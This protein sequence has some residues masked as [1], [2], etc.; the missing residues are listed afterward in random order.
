M[1]Q[2]RPSS[3]HAEESAVGS[4]HDQTCTEQA[5]EMGGE[6]GNKEEWKHKPTHHVAVIAVGPL[7]FHVF[8]IVVFSNATR[9]DLTFHGHGRAAASSHTLAMNGYV[10]FLMVTGP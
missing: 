6:R 8:L 1:S 4:R 3:H 2:K 5:E 9:R 7:P 10:P